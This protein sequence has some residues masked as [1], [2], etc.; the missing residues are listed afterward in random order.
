M[1]RLTKIAVGLLAFN[2]VFFFLARG[3]AQTDLNALK[4]RI[5]SIE[6][7][8]PLRE[9][10]SAW[11]EKVM[12]FVENPPEEDPTSLLG[13]LRELANGWHFEV[14]EA[15][16]RGGTPTNIVFIGRG[17]YRAI[18]AVISEIERSEAT[19]LDS[20]SL[21]RRDEE[22]IDA[23]FEMSIRRGPW[24]EISCDQ[25]P[26]PATQT[27]E[28]HQLSNDPFNTPEATMAAPTLKPQLRF[29]GFFSSASRITA[30]IEAGNKVMLLM[31]GERLPGGES[32]VTASA[33]RLEIQDGK[34]NRWTYEIEKAR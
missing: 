22:T 34:G 33:E 11:L 13:R 21:V 14:T 16:N 12:P 10:N 9:A 23:S 19:R 24:V 32:M 2:V 8:L 4:V 3:E 26:E 30:I 31:P 27:S 5:A 1:D 17:S 7:T 28:I 6:Q 20:L 29:T 15:A 25:R 18:A